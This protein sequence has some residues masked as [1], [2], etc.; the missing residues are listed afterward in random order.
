MEIRSL[1]IEYVTTPC[2][3]G[4]GYS[5]GGHAQLLVGNYIFDFGKCHD[6]A[7]YIKKLSEKCRQYREVLEDIQVQSEPKSYAYKEARKILGY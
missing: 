5:W 1:K 3:D 2:H 7:E 4:D 6:E